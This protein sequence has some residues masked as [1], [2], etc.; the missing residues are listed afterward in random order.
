[1]LQ[2]FIYE[3]AVNNLNTTNTCSVVEFT[4]ILLEHYLLI[5]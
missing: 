3:N 2:D 1:M 4:K 5:I